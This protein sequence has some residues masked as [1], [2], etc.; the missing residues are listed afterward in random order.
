MSVRPWWLLPPG[1]IHAAWGIALGG[2]CLSIDYLV[3]AS[4]PFPSAYVVPVIIASWYSGKW[5]GVALAV[6]VPVIRTSVLVWAP[7]PAVDQVSLLAATLLRAVGV[8]LVGLW[9]ARLADFE[10]DLTRQVRVLEGLLPI[11]A[12]C[13]SIRNE[14]GKWERLESFISRKSEAEFSHG[15]CPSCGKTHYP[16]MF[17]AEEPV[18]IERVVR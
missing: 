18:S 14:G 4:S 5:A 16:D 17:D 9:F 7:S 2:L 11:C 15:I 8:L 1:Q 13:K 10:R 12:F 3:N 6:A